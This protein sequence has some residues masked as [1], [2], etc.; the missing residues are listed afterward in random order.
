MHIDARTIKLVLS[1][2]DAIRR[3]IEE[4][5]AAAAAEQRQLDAGSPERL[6]WH[7]GYQAALT[8]LID[9]VSFDQ[10]QPNSA[11]IPN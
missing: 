10:S 4:N 5:G 7:C 6:Y 11:G 3:W 2:R 1:Q 8:D 9:L